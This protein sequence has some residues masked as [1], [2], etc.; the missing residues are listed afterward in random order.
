MSCTETAIKTL[1]TRYGLCNG[2]K[3]GTWPK[4]YTAEQI[5][6][7][8]KNV[9]GCKYKELAILFNAEFGTAATESAIGQT[10]RKRGLRN[11]VIERFPKGHVPFNKGRKGYCSPGSEKGWFAPGHPGYKYNEMPVG[12]E[13]VTA[14]GYVEVKF[15]NKS[16][17]PKNRWKNKHALIWEEANGPLPKGHVVL[18]GDGNR[19]NFKLDNLILVSR[20]ELFVINHIGLLSTN[21]DITKIGVNVAKLKV[22]SADRKRGTWK[23]N[24]KKKLV[25]IDNK[26]KRVF[27]A[28]D[29]KRKR[30][31]PARDTKNG[32]CRL[33]AS[34]KSRKTL[35]EAQKDLTE[36]A[37]KRGWH[38]V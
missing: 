22:L 12:S 11:G 18:F 37:Q 20:R 16:G 23:S 34:L 32:V 4:K 21:K 17:P 35:E 7:L 1:C 24:K 9:K 28:Y 31:I 6:F 27:I 2:F 30:Y 15:S 36:Y 5:L 3:N 29:E 10:C 33:Q 25:V 38:R 13:R 8:K 19:R 14:D 26:G